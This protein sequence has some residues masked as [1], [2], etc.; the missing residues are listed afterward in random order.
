MARE[1]GSEPEDLTTVP[2]V[3]VHQFLPSLGYRDAKG[4]HTR[5]TQAVLARAGH[6]GSIWAEDIHP[7]LRRSARIYTGY[8]RTRSAK[9]GGNVVLYQASTGTRG[10]ADFLL[11]RPERKL[12]YYHCITPASFFERY[13]GAASAALARGREELKVLVDQAVGAMANSAFSARELEDL[14]APNVVVVPPYLPPALSTEP[15]PSHTSWLRSTKRGVDILFVSRVVPH[16]GHLHLLRAFAAFRAGVDPNAR[17]FL[18]GAWGPDAYT[19]A[20]FRLR[21]R[22]GSQGVVFTGS[23]DEAHL[24]AHYREADVYLSLSE[25]EGFGLPL[26]EAMREGL[27]VLAYDAAAVA[28]TLGGTG[29]LVR[30]LDAAFIAETVARVAGDNDLKAALVVPQR[31]RVAEIE[32]APRDA[33][34]LDTV[35]RAVES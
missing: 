7:E 6:K 9:R 32:A 2:R 12:L 16:K 18:V 31:E 28:E 20:I 11:E 8:E 24:K 3:G 5:V 1:P 26:V 14:G 15:S 27:P 34:L 13:D 25:H 4:T 30:T 23:I 33:L 17:L 35:R 22:L 29:V 19:D 10:L 21:D